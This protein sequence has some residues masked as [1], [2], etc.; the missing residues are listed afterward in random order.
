MSEQT[1]TGAVATTGIRS[2]TRQMLAGWG[3][4]PRS[5]ADV[6]RPIGLREVSPLLAEARGA[7]RSVLARGLGRAYGDAATSTGAVVLDLTGFDRILEFDPEQRA[8]TVEAGMSLDA[9][10]R[11]SVPRGFFVP[12]TPGT[13]HVTVGGAIAADVHG[14]NHHREGSIGNWLAGLRLATP[15]GEIELGPGTDAEGYWAT[16]GGMGLTGVI[17]EATLRLLPIETSLV[18]VDTE[19]AANLDDCMS[20][21]DEGDAGYRYSVAWVDCVRRGR[22]L[23]RAVLTRG[24]HASM[25][26]L[27]VSKPPGG[28]SRS[29][30]LAYG[31]RQL[32][33]IPIDA[34]LRLASVP[35]VTAF[36]EAWFRKSPRRRIGEL[37]GLATFFHPLDVLG[38]WNRL[39]GRRGFTQY[40]VA[41]PFGAEHVVRDLIE[42]LSGRGFPSLLAVLKRFG[43][44]N[45]APLSFPTAGWTLALDIPL[46]RPG[47]A[48]LLDRTDADVASAGGRVYFAKD[49]RL[50]PDLVEEMYP[51]LAEWRSVRDRLDPDAVLASDLGRRVGLVQPGR[52]R[53]T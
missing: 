21:M 36:N 14:K 20:R 15:A 40:Q 31:P 38:G 24:D 2:G 18:K 47:L 42:A 46:G 51:R 45:P 10:L 49:G 6:V 27:D 3:G 22:S 8:V 35:S 50:R 32:A 37:Q 25:E 43:P 33:A 30:P 4:S 48:A 17:L 23:G 34:P 1:L 13:R 9:L 53:P 11:W 44:S 12:V 28:V 26:D 41:V 5:V 7:G 19:R 29:E 39:Y 52:R 16:V